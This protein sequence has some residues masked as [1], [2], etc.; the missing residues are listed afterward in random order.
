MKQ[1]SLKASRVILFLLIASTSIFSTE[2][3]DSAQPFLILL[4]LAELIGLL[5]HIYFIHRNQFAF[6]GGGLFTK[7]SDLKQNLQA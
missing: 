5:I 2:N 6:G 7:L 3:P 4:V 1:T